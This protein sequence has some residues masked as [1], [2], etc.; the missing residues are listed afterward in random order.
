M[1]TTQIG[2]RVRAHY[3]KRFSDGSV[4]SSRAHG[5]A[6]LEVTIGTDHPRLRGLGTELVG[7]A[8]GRTVVVHVPPERAYGLPDPGRIHRVDRARFHA[9]EELTAGRM[10]WVR[11]SR[12]RT[13]RVRVLEVRGRTVVVDTNHPRSGQSVEM[14]L[15]VVAILA[16]N[17]GAAN[18]GP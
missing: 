17:T 8:V 12:G 6:P 1:R 13:R 11:L 2:D 5:S 18:R 15:E 16:P 9:D 14:E 3:T 4:R 7:V 10:V